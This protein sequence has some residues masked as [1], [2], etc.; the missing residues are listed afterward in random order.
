MLAIDAN[1]RCAIG[2][3]KARIVIVSRMIAT[4]KL[5]I[6]RNSQSR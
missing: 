5:P 3:S 6:I 2:N 4:P 1:W